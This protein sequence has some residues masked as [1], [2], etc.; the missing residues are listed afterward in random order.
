MDYMKTCKQSN[1][2]LPQGFTEN[3]LILYE[4]N[5]EGQLFI[6]TYVRCHFTN[7]IEMDIQNLSG[8][9][10]GS[11]HASFYL[12]NLEITQENTQLAKKFNKLA[13][14]SYKLRKLSNKEKKQLRN[15]KLMQKLLL[16]N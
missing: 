8:S 3:S 11:M 15:K 1:D 10:M 13:K 7:M 9:F 4:G 5:K 16:R 2:Q 6:P 12:G 14:V